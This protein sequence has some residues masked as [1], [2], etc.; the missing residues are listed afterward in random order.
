MFNLNNFLTGMAVIAVIICIA[1]FAK[2]E[3]FI[4]L[5]NVGVS[6]DVGTKAA[7]GEVNFT[8]AKAVNLNVATDETATVG[9]NLTDILKIGHESVRVYVERRH[10]LRGDLLRDANNVVGVTVSF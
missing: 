7:V 8:V 5:D 3:P 4:K 2:A 1:T 9:L 10:D 6:M